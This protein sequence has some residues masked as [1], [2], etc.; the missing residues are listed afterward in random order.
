MYNT[1]YTF[2]DS[3]LFGEESETQIL[4]FKSLADWYLNKALNIISSIKNF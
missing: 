3:S 4:D 1:K 2:K